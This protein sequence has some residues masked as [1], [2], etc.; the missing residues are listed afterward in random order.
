MKRSDMVLA[1]VVSGACLVVIWIVM[2]SPKK[3]EEMPAAERREKATAELGADMPDEARDALYPETVNM[4]DKAGKV[5]WTPVDR[6]RGAYDR[7]DRFVDTDQLEVDDGV[8]RFK[9]TG[10]E[11]NALVAS[12]RFGI[13]W[14]FHGPRRKVE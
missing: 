1:L 13:L 7:G 3:V 9:L 10:R 14:K 11:V 6:W 12:G 8:K 2:V 5:W 4:V